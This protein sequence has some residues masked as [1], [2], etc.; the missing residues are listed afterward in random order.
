MPTPR[1]RS[2]QRENSSCTREWGSSASR[3]HSRHPLREGSEL[4]TRAFA[5][6]LARPSVHTATSDRNDG[7][8]VV[9]LF[10][11]IL[12]HLGNVGDRIAESLGSPPHLRTCGGCPTAQRR[13]RSPVPHL[14]QAAGV[15][16]TRIRRRCRSAS[17][18][19]PGLRPWIRCPPEFA[20]EVEPISSSSILTTTAPPGGILS[21]R[22]RAGRQHLEKPSTCAVVMLCHRS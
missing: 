10:D 22:R 18:L 6:A 15:W 3:I 17:P 7:P 11:D 9:T 16:L 14:T 1:I 13:A 4:T 12:A 20:T 19:G 21:R 2:F 5:A 8:D